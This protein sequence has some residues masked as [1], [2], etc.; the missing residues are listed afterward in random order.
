MMRAFA[1]PLLGAAALWAAAL[2]APTF[3]LAGEVRDSN[4]AEA[5]LQQMLAEI[6][7]SP[8]LGDADVGVHV[9]SLAD[10]RTVFER[11]SSKLF[12]PASNVKLVTTAAALAYLGPSYRFKTIAY[13]D[14]AMQGGVVQGNL[15]IKGFGDPTLTD[16]QLFGFVNEIALG[17]ISEIRGDLVVDDS[18]FD[19]V[20]EGPGWEQE[21]SDRS[22]APSMGAF[23]INFG[24]FTVRVLPGDSVGA[25]ARVKLWPDVPSIEVTSTA[26][27]QGAGSRSRIWVGT[28]RGDGGKVLVNVRG[29]V[30]AGETQGATFYRRAYHP[31]LYAGEHL[32]NML[33][34]RGV[35]IKGKVRRGALNRSGVPVATHFSRPLAE[36]VSVLNKFSNNFIAEQI[37]KTLG[38]E[39]RGE[40]GSWQKGADVLA[41]FLHEVGV[42]PGSFVLGNG[43]GLNDINRLTPEQITRMLDA[44]FARFEVAPEF[45]ASLAVAGASGTINSRFAN[46][47]AVARLRAKTGSLTGV[48][49]LSGYVVSK[50]GEIFAFSVMMNG[51]TGR[52]RSMW[53]VQDRIGNTLAEFRRGEVLAQP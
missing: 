42:P 49:A 18:F 8:E 32:K 21:L 25:D 47:P 27:T 41:Q 15:Y 37:L 11:N 14:R 6:L 13:R 24:T 36:V 53:K 19:D 20:Y 2:I 10:G 12:N 26:V 39:L 16:E 48:S 3:A 43:S 7:R 33:E 17:G 29:G 50:D 22:Y 34:M 23:A 1:R 45:I 5:R 28:S 44:M 35:K 4:A 46:S 40:P 51:Y 38:A 52:T 31:T 30:S 9:R